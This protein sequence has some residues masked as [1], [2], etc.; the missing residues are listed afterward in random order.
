MTREEIKRK[1]DELA[2]E[3]YCRYFGAVVKSQGLRWLFFRAPGFGHHIKNLHTFC[4]RQEK[5]RAGAGEQ[6]LW[7]WT[8]NIKKSL[9]R[10]KLAELREVADYI[11]VR[12]AKLEDKPVPD[13]A[14]FKTK[15]AEREYWQAVDRIKRMSMTQ[16]GRLWGEIAYRRR[17]LAEDEDYVEKLEYRIE[18]LLNTLAR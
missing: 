13:P 6:Y 17:K 12:I 11:A 3:R 2:R 16:L 9:A 10:L 18:E 14:L 8:V 15:A 1:M 5:R 4:R 7:R